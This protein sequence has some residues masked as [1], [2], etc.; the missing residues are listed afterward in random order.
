MTGSGSLPQEVR[1]GFAVSF[2]VACAFFT[3]PAGRALVVKPNYRDD[4]QFVGG[5]VDKGESPHDACA[6]EVK[7][8]IG[9]DMPVGDLLVLDYEPDHAFVGAPMTTYVFD[10]G[11]ID[12]PDLIRLQADELEEF[13]FLP[14]ESAARLFADFS[15]ARLG[16]AAEARRTGKTVF[17]PYFPGCRDETCLA[18]IS[19]G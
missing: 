7:E 18:A 1:D 15:R 3:D 17:Q 16:L 11:V 8:E 14:V 13:S 12:D 9:L 19:F 10:G 4:W 2:A 5:M 6:R